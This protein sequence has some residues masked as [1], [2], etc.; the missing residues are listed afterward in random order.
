MIV[1]E[2]NWS[3]GLA[4][5]IHTISSVFLGPDEFGRDRYE[6]RRSEM[7]EFVYQLKYKQDKS[8]L[9]AIIKLLDEVK[10]V[11]KFHYI[12]PVPPTSQSRPFQPVREIAVALGEHRG[13]NV[14]INFLSKSAGGPE[15][16]NVTSA[17]QR[18]ALLREHMS[19]SNPSIIA[20]RK[21]L[22][23]DDLYRSG[24]TLRAATQLLL[25]AGAQTVCVLA[26][27]KTR[28]NR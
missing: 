18:E 19:I 9:A 28:S 3:K 4:Y 22:L 14:L 24:A 1:I 23:V 16:K 13:V 8:A 6:N 27:T 10:N 7:G 11:E 25:D 5:D 21:A 15:L 17:E 20:G 2:G 26:M 12:I